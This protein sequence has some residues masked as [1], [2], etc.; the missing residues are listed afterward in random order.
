MNFFH[1]AFVKIGGGGIG[2][3]E[4]TIIAIVR[5]LNFSKSIGGGPFQVK[6]IKEL[7]IIKWNGWWIFFKTGVSDYIISFG[8]FWFI[9]KR[10]GGSDKTFFY[11]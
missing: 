8:L 7:D 1:F 5:W 9:T 6:S 10:A 3:G 11:C 4:E 2:E